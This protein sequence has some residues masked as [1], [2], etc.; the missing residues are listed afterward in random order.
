MLRIIFTFVCFWCVHLFCPGT[1]AQNSAANTTALLQRIQD[2]VTHG[3]PLVVT[4]YV[5]LCDN[6]SQGIIPVKNRAI[7]NGDDPL[8]NIYWKGNG[9]AGYLKAHQWHKVQSRQDVSNTVVIEEVWSKTQFAS[10]ALQK[11]GFPRQ[12]SVSI[13]AKAYRG[14]RIGDAMKDYLDAVNND[15]PQTIALSDGR[16]L[17]GGGQSH[18]V[19][20]IGHNYMM[21]VSE[22]TSTW[23]MLKHTW[24][25]GTST[26]PKGTFALACESNAY[27]RPFV[28]RQNIYILMMNKF[29]TYP[30]AWTVGGIIDGLATGGDGNSIFKHGVRQFAKGQQCGLC[31]AKKAFSFGP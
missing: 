9:I 7:C 29:L 5:A 18:L 14:N 26:T 2:D 16:L 28:S 20:Y 4:V 24:S 31:W 22:G 3:K 23:W 12:F 11:M 8:K 13:I 17:Q 1:N 6:D 25:K 30:S 10:T 21:D 19:G 27:I 15:S